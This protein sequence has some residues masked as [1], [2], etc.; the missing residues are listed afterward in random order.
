[1]PGAYF[2][3]TVEICVTLE[4]GR[5]ADKVA[6]REL[7]D[8]SPRQCRRSI[9]A[10]FDIFGKGPAGSGGSAEG[11]LLSGA[12]SLRSE[13]SSCSTGPTRS[14]GNPV[15]SSPPSALPFQ[16]APSPH[17]RATGHSLRDIPRTSFRLNFLPPWL[18]SKARETQSP[19][20]TGVG[21]GR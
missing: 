7:D 1:M 21:S 18:K 16:K 14:F 13:D 15:S 6:P 3:T 5:S 9:A 11:E 2:F 20:P 4:G 19:A 17:G 12:V 8:L 10:R